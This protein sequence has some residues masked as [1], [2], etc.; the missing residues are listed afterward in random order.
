MEAVL[1]KFNFYTS[2]KAE[3]LLEHKPK[4]PVG[5]RYIFLMPF[6]R[7]FKRYILKAGFLD[8]YQGFIAIFFAMI[9]FPVRYFKYLELK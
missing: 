4:F 2:F 1:H 7:F 8:G 3:Y 9:N 6:K 5:F